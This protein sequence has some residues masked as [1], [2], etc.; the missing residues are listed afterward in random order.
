VVWPTIATAVASAAL[1]G[2]VH[3]LTSVLIND[4]G[5]GMRIAVPT[6]ALTAI[7]LASR[8]GVLIKGAN[9]LELLARA[10]VVIFD[11]T[12]TLSTG[13]PGVVDVRALDSYGQR[14]IVAFCAAAEA[15][16]SHPIAAAVR[17]HA[18]ALG[19]DVP[20]TAPGDA[21]HVIGRGTPLVAA[22]VGV[23]PLLGQ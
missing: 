23:A 15:R 20:M 11:K 12:G 5:T 4:F 7:T 22:L 16:Q 17:R 3:R 9:Y 6:N 1:S 21:R 19:V 10:D 18:G 2:E 8:G 13:E 14:D